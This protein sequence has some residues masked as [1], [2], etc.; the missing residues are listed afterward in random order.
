MISASN[1]AGGEQISRG[2]SKY[3]MSAVGTVNYEALEMTG[4]DEYLA[5]VDVWA[6]ECLFRSCSA[7][8]R[9]PGGTTRKR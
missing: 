3:F 6:S 8:C 4:H 9:S 1:I 7:A 2:K 5:A